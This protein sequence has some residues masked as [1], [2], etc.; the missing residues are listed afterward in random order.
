M[1]FRLHQ[2]VGDFERHCVAFCAAHNIPLVTQRVNAAN[3]P[4]QSPEDAARRARYRAFSAL[5]LVEYAQQAIKIVAKPQAM[6]LAIAQH[7]DDQVE[8]ILLALSRG[9]AFFL[10]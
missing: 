2:I 5:A 10:Q 9:A 7:A 8:T 1:G 3:S 4:G 6:H